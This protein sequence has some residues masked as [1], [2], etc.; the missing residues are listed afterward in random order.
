[1]IEIHNYL[2]NKKNC[3]KWNFEDIVM[4]FSFEGT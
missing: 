3:E 4:L 1:M 2:L